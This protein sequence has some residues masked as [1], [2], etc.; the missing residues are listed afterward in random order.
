MADRRQRLEGVGEAPLVGRSRHEL[1][2]AL[3]ALGAHGLRV[4]AAFLP[5]EPHED[6]WRQPACIRLLAHQRADDIDEGHRARGDRRGC[7][8]AAI[9]LA[10]LRRQRR[11][12]EQEKG[13]G[14]NA[15]H[16]GESARGG[17]RGKAAALSSERC[18]VREE[19]GRLR[20]GTEDPPS[21]PLSTSLSTPS[22]TKTSEDK[23]RSC[24]RS[25]TSRIARL[26]IDLARSLVKY[27]FPV[28]ALYCKSPAKAMRLF[29]DFVSVARLAL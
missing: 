4:E 5:D 26:F 17:R 22:Q 13:S 28:R 9:D 10:A 21:A 20:Y 7:L 27:S 29:T 23:A 12:H 24:T 19:P 1:S 15:R 18:G 8:H 2:D 16:A 3:R 11:E 6:H 14:R 25:F